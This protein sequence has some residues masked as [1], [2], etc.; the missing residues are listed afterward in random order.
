VPVTKRWTEVTD[1]YEV[2]PPKPGDSPNNSTRYRPRAGVKETELGSSLWL[3]EV[4]GKDVFYIEHADNVRRN[5]YGPIA[6]DPA[7]K[8]RP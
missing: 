2:D 4:P 3:Y 1:I 7:K 8:L 6:G 5:V